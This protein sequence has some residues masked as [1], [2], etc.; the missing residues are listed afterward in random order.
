LASV[1]AV[2]TS[3]ILDLGIGLLAVNASANGKCVTGSDCGG[4]DA[5]YGANCGG[6]DTGYSANCSPSPT[7]STSSPTGSP[8][9]TP[10]STPSNGPHVPTPGTTVKATT[11]LPT[12]GGPTVWFVVLGAMLLGAGAAIM[13]IARRRSAL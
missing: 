4:C 8:T 6:C 13:R 12:T 9:P 5:G 11:G 10:T 2:H 3:T 7:P 1:P